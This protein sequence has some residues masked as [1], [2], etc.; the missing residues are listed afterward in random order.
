M[1]AMATEISAAASEKSW[2][3]SAAHEKPLKESLEDASVLLWYAT[4]EGKS[5][6]RE[7]VEHI[8][9]AQFMLSRKNRDPEVEGQF[10]VAF[11]DLATAIRP[12]SVDSIL[13]TYSYPFGD[14]GRPREHATG[15]RA[16]WAAP[17]G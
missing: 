14:H 2:E 13:A 9:A 16:W 15:W 6:S 17:R 5:V 3:Q 8:V 1:T 7:T 11:R 12:V 10:W 4:R